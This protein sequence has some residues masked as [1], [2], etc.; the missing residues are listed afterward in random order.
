MNQEKTKMS[1]SSKVILIIVVFVVLA[2]V[3]YAVTQGTGKKK[4]PPAL[5]G[6]IALT[7]E[8]LI[9]NWV[10]QDGNLRHEI[11][12]E[13]GNKM[14]YGCYEPEDILPST[15]SSNGSYSISGNILSFTYTIETEESTEQYS[16]RY[17][18]A[19]SAEKLILSP[20]EEKRGTLKGTYINDE[21]ADSQSESSSPS[22]GSE[23]SALESS[24]PNSSQSPESSVPESTP[25]K[26]PE[27]SSEP[28][29]STTPSTPEPEPEP[30]PEPAQP[31]A[32]NLTG[33]QLAGTVWAGE[34]YQIRFNSADT[35]ELLDFW[36]NSY[37]A[38]SYSIN[39]SQF[40][41]ED[42]LV[43]NISFR[44][45]DPLGSDGSYRSKGND[46]MTISGFEALGV[47]GFDG[48]YNGAFGYGVGE[49]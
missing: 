1:Q 13:Y 22:N 18:A 44:L 21:Y 33:E 48:Q 28:P 47:S 34:Y 40:I 26:P 45:S 9:A 16:E 39:G 11:C 32:A 42:V 38:L 7:E 23:S 2:V 10:R 36:G 24:S 35:F 3:V 31:I 8:N 19:V 12:F 5:E 15:I 25:S 49:H 20:V 27:V 14:S 29:A 37:G 30:T 46:V 17:Y 41:L 43:G 4:Q 6:Q